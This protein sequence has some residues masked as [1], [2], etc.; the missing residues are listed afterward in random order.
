MKSK[1]WVALSAIC[2]SSTFGAG[3][4]EIDF[5]E[6]RSSLDVILHDLRHAQA[7]IYDLIDTGNYKDARSKY[8]SISDVCD[9]YILEHAEEK[10]DTVSNKFDETLTL[11]ARY[12]LDFGVPFE[13][14]AE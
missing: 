1:W 8:K 11:I 13:E 7:T 2:I 5:E 4:L 10:Q 9:C 12:F 14:E 6:E 3:T